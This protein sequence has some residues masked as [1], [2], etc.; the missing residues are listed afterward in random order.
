[1]GESCQVERL[2]KREKVFLK[3]DETVF[4]QPLLHEL[5]V[6]PVLTEKKD[7]EFKVYWRDKLTRSIALLGSITERRKKERTDNLNDLLKRV[8]S[9][10]SGQVKDP[11]GIFLLGS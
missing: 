1:L 10:F 4:M 7:P 3:D 6:G 8:I 5:E 2:D 9:D 11:I